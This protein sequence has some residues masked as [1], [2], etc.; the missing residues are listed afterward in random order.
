[1]ERSFLELNASYDV[2][3]DIWQALYRGPETDTGVL[4]ACNEAGVTLV[5]YSPMSQ[6][7]LTGKYDVGGATPGVGRCRLTV[8]KPVL[9]APMVSAISA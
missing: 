5:A 1:L 2:A 8:S 3:S 9:K 7:L 4:E 6:G